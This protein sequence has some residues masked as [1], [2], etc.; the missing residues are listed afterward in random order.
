MRRFFAT[1]LVGLMLT[2]TS[3][4]AADN[5]QVIAPA[6][7][8]AAAAAIAQNPA[9][10]GNQTV[11]ANIDFSPRF[12]TEKRPM[13]LPALYATTV[14]LQAYDAY[15]TLTV[16][17]NGGVEANPVMKGL[18]KNAPAF[19]ALKAGVAA[20]SIMAAEKM[21]KDHNK[22]GAIVTMLA[23]NGFMAYVA[24]HNAGVLNQVR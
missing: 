1:S 19:V 6:V 2:S 8:T 15:S 13:V 9:L 22:V 18:T 24:A 23:S 20:M 21:W 3:A 12:G 14:G 11:A 5:G 4:F 17:K 7:T 16:L 10:A